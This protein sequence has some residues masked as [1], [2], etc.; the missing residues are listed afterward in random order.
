MNNH[1]KTKFLGFYLNNDIYA[2]PITDICEIN[3]IANLY[4]EK[5]FDCTIVGMINYHG[6]TAPVYNLKKILNMSDFNHDSFTMWFAF[7]HLSDVTCFAFDSLYRMLHATS[8]TIDNVSDHVSMINH[9]QYIQN[10][11]RIDEKLIPV[12]KL[13]NWGPE[14]K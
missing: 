10:Y 12:L 8:D 5:S 14:I 2:I 4:K 9:K 1:I 7:K 11:I 3:R 6:K 13:E